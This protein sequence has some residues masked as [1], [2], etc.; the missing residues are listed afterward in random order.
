MFARTHRAGVSNNRESSFRTRPV[1]VAWKYIGK[2]GRNAEQA[3]TREQEGSV[4]HEHIGETAFHLKFWTLINW[5]CDG[6]PIAKPNYGGSVVDVNIHYICKNLER[7][8]WRRRF[9]PWAYNLRNRSRRDYAFSCRHSFWDSD[10]KIRNRRFFEMD[11]NDGG[12]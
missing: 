2:C 10:T 6:R 12:N 8:S 4:P 1:C 3:P 5:K 11:T 7:C 9:F